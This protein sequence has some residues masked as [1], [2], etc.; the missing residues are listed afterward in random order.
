MLELYTEIFKENAVGKYLNLELLSI[1]VE[2]L[3]PKLSKG[4][5]RKENYL[6]EVFIRKQPIHT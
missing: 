5:L 2:L 4:I 3:P 6:C 1:I